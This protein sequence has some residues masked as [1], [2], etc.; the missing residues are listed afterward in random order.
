LSR[1][2][3]NILL[4]AQEFLVIVAPL[5]VWSQEGP[6]TGRDALII[7]SDSHGHWTWEDVEGEFLNPFV[8]I[9][10]IEL[11][12]VFWMT[13]ES[14]TLANLRSKSLIERPETSWTKLLP[15]PRVPVVYS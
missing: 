9:T 12:T 5:T 6:V 7:L 15:S 13:E 11:G 14:W 4:E 8:P 1:K 10:F 2:K 3:G